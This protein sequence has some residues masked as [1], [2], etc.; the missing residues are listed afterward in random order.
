MPDG[1]VRP[2][3]AALLEGFR[4]LSSAEFR[5]RRGLIELALRTQ[6]ITFTAYGDAEGTEGPFPFDPFPR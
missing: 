3:Y 4:A 2:H 5:R 1:S 6:A